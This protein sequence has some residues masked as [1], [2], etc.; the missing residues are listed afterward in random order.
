MERERSEKII[1]IGMLSVKIDVRVDVEC[2]GLYDRRHCWPRRQTSVVV[3][4]AGASSVIILA[5]SA[6]SA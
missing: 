2:G 4:D 3:A 5:T 1:Y 6:A